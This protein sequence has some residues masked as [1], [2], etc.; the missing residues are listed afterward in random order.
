MGL[1]PSSGE[2]PRALCGLRTARGV[3]V[4]LKKLQFF[5]ILLKNCIFAPKA[6]DA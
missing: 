5:N 2:W 1:Y 4:E 3:A 6:S